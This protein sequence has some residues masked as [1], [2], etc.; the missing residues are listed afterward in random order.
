MIRRYSILLTKRSTGE[1]A[2]YYSSGSS[3]AIVIYNL[4]PYTSYG[5][6][7]AAYTIA[8]GPYSPSLEI[9]TLPDGKHTTYI[10]CRHVCLVRYYKL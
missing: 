2:Q 6:S 9:V 10:N 4:D 3:E 5:A 1:V 7:I 8:L